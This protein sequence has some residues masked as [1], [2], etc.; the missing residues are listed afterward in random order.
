MTGFFVNIVKLIAVFAVFGT[1]FISCEPARAKGIASWY[2]MQSL[3]DEKTYERTKGVMA[4]GDLFDD[5]ALTC[6]CY[7]YPLGANLIVRN[8]SN[9]KTVLVRVT[10]RGPAEEFIKHGRI[11]DLSR[12]AFRR[13]DDLDRGLIEVEITKQREGAWLSKARLRRLS[14]RS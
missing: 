6:A 9:N 8:L 7:Y 13:L 11:I 3:K 2:S 1:M 10:D 12:E 14:Q 4:N 5:K